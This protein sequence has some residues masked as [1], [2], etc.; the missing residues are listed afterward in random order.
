[1]MSAGSQ[2]PQARMIAET[3]F[4]VALVCAARFATLRGGE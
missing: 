1:M 4:R 2:S 3:A